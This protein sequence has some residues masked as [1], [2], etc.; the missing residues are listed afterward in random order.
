MAKLDTGDVVVIPAV[1]RLS[2]D[3]TNLLVI[4]RDMRRR[5]RRGKV[6]RRP[7]A[8]ATW[9]ADFVHGK[10]IG[11]PDQV[12]QPGFAYD[13]RPFGGSASPYTS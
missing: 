8:A 11:G 10:R 1:D 2:R 12:F 7:G 6:G 13:F 3:T 4:A 9:W 5:P